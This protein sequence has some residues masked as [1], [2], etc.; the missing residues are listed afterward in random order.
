MYALARHSATHNIRIH[1]RLVPHHVWGVALRSTTSAPGVFKP[2]STSGDAKEDAKGNLDAAEKLGTLPS[3]F[4][5]RSPGESPYRKSSARPGKAAADRGQDL[6]QRW[7][8]LER[9]H[10]A[11]KGLIQEKEEIEEEGSENMEEV[12]AH[13]LAATGKD[14]GK[15]NVETF[16][17]LVIPKKPDP[18][19]DDGASYLSWSAVIMREL[20]SWMYRVLHVRL[21]NLRL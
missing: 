13:G 19:A 8:Q 17:G 10:R 1:A 6:S 14:V 3:T 20:T 5:R 15:E 11:K 16:K 2:S 7:V 21:R 12:K 9:T 4:T 18:P